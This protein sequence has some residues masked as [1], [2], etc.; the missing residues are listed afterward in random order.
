MHI[1]ALELLG[2]F[3]T[4]RSLL[5]QAVP[6][7]QWS[8]VHLNCQLDNI[9]AIKYAR[10]AV[11]RSLAL[12]RL[13]AQFYD[14][15]ENAQLQMSFRHLAG[16]Y[17]V[18]ADQLSRKEWQEIEWKLDPTVVGRLQQIWK[19]NISRDLFASRQNTQHERFYSWE[20]DFAAQGVDSLAHRWHWKQT[21]YA[22]PPTFLLSRVLQKI[23][24]ERIYDMILI[25]PLFPLQ[26]WW[27]LLMETL[28]EA[29][30]I[31]PSKSWLTTDPAGQP[32]YRHVWPL[33]AWRVSGDLRYAKQ[34]RHEMRYG[35]NAIGFQGWIRK[36][37]RRLISQ[38]Q[39]IR[40]ET[41]L[42]RSILAT[43]AYR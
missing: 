36:S 43:Q 24:H 39:Q 41:I 10:V 9:V 16:I 3:Y 8:Q 19:C 11:S 12:S 35:K 34:R 27:P 4:I 17:N 2:C 42:I 33:I 38:S 30:M 5:P 40:N 13:G 6:R 26:S 14:W 31:L 15:A 7:D 29:P 20:H 1:N 32:T 28:V 37:T 23:I 21:I 25:T 22:Y 18:E